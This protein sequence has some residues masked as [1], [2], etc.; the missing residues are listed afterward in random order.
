MRL[1][2]LFRPLTHQH[3]PLRRHGTPIYRLLLL[4][5][6][7]SQMPKYLIDILQFIL[8]SLQRYRLYLFRFKWTCILTELNLLHILQA[9]FWIC[10]CLMSDTFKPSDNGRN[11]HECCLRNSGLGTVEVHHWVVQI[12]WDEWWCVLQDVAYFVWCCCY[13]LPV[14]LDQDLVGIAVSADIFGFL[15]CCSFQGPLVDVLTAGYREWRA[16]TQ[17]QYVG[18]TVEVASFRIEYEVL[19]SY[20][21]FD[22]HKFCVSLNFLLQK[23]FQ[24]ITLLHTPYFGLATYKI[25]IWDS[26]CL[27]LL[28]SMWSFRI[29]WRPVGNMLPGF[30][31]QFSIFANTAEVVVVYFADSCLLSRQ[32]IS[33]I[34]FELLSLRIFHWLSSRRGVWLANQTLIQV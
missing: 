14:V 22:I 6:H 5:F 18:W 23:V 4:F 10:W 19:V 2:V 9:L 1:L 13:L 27:I 33:V 25:S 20:W 24:R 28:W 34:L 8:K 16:L 17:V 15:F 31:N 30:I 29:V 11:L 12:S 21:L 3:L 32:L 26:A 7:N